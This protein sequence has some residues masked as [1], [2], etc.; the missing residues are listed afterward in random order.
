MQDYEKSMAAAQAAP[1]LLDVFQIVDSGSTH[2]TLLNGQ[3]LSA[4]KMASQPHPLKHLDQL[5]LGSTVIEIHAHEEGRICS[6]C[7]I[8]DSNE[9]EVLDDKESTGPAGAAEK[10][11]VAAALL[12]S[13]NASAL[14]LDQKLT[15]E[16]ERIEEMNRLKKKWAGPEKRS[17]SAGVRRSG[18]S[19]HGQDNL[20]TS[21]DG[22]STY[23][24]RA[25]KRR[26]YNPDHSQPVHS[27][28][29]T[30]VEE[31][32]AAT[33]FHVPVAKTNKGHAM[34]SKMGWRAGTGLGALGQGV[35]EPVQLKVSDKKAGLGSTTLQSQ[36]VAAAAAGSS[37][38]SSRE[39]QGEAARRR[40]RERFARLK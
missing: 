31:T 15:T 28:Q 25:A 32:V 36:G 23:V 4:A 26:L 37:S 30:Q 38:P 39:T 14:R 20:A 2:G 6:R 18:T 34:L 33:G 29:Y 21:E 10:A 9:I 1:V 40:A 5:Q 8:T 12:A 16:Q 27:V 3:R 13:K 11:A 19:G 17:A 24:D 7:Q 35:V 22:S